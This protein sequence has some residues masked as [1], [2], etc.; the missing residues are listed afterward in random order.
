MGPDGMAI[1]NNGHLWVAIPGGGMLQCYS[2]ETGEQVRK[3]SHLS[4]LSRFKSFIGSLIHV[5]H[6]L[7]SFELSR[8]NKRPCNAFGQYPDDHSVEFES[9]Q[10]CSSVQDTAIA[11]QALEQLMKASD[12]REK[13]RPHSVNTTSICSL[14]TCISMCRWHCPYRILHAVHLAERTWTSCMSQA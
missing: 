3:V 11:L 6:L 7:H 5:L 1:S 14:L 2:A 9:Y 8:R 13:I 10:T 4:A 12:F